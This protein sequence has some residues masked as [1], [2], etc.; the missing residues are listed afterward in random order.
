[1]YSTKKNLLSFLIAAE[2][3]FLGLDLGFIGVSLIN[4][5][6][7]GIIYSLIILILAV[8]E[9]AV[10]LSLCVIGLKIDDNISF[11]QFNKLKY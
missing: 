4:N 8:G 6:P 1:M 11:S 2:I 9:S 3:M 5:H 7:L 10:G